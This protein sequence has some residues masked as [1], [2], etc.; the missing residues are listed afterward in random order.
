MHDQAHGPG[1]HMSKEEKM[2]AGKSKL[3]SQCLQEKFD[4]GL[5]ESNKNLTRVAVEAIDMDWIF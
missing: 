2:L 4:T 1:Q 3:R 5:P